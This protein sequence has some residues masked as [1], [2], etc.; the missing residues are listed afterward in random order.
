MVAANSVTLLL[1]VKN[2]YIYIEV[3][4]SINIYTRAV[5][6]CGSMHS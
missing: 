6:K 4:E 5:S 1:Y 2:I 3:I